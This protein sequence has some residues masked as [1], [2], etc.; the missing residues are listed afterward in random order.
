MT[1]EVLRSTAMR[2][3]ELELCDLPLEG[4]EASRVGS[5]VCANIHML[6]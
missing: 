6:A 2:Y 1:R 5:S 3:S 4:H